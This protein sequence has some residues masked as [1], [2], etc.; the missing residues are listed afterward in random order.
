MT[1]VDDLQQQCICEE[2]Y[3]PESLHEFAY[4]VEYECP[5]HGHQAHYQKPEHR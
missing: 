2:P 3:H 5:V 4:W 1:R